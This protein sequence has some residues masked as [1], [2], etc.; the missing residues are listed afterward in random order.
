MSVSARAGDLPGTNG[1][2]VP[3][4]VVGEDG[5]YTP[6]RGTQSTVDTNEVHAPAANTA[7]VLT[8]AA[9]TGVAHAVKDLCFS[10]AGSGALSGGNLKIEDGSDTV[11]SIDISTKEWGCLPITRRGTAGRAMTITLAAGG[12]DVS[13]KV[14]ASHYTVQVSAGGFADLGDEMNSGLMVLFF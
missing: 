11:F 8:Y 2:G 4:L 3:I 6:L 7:A 14:N 13:G 1:L 12:A 5:A 10:Y 9:E